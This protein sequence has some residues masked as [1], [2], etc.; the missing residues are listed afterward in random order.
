MYFYSF[1][2]YNCTEILYFFRGGFVILS[3][4]ACLS[5]AYHHYN[6]PNDFPVILISG[7][8]WR[9]PDTP[10]EKLFFHNC[11]EIGLCKS[12][13]GY[14]QFLQEQKTFQAGDIS[15]IGR[16]VAHHLYSANACSSNWSYLFVDL[17]LLLSSFYPLSL[18]ADEETIHMAL[19]NCSWLLSKKRH[20]RIYEIVLMMMESLANKKPNYQITVRSLM[21]V[22]VTYLLN[23]YKERK[24]LTQTEYS[25]PWDSP[26]ILPALKYIRVHYAE[27]FSTEILSGLCHMSSTNFRRTF[28]G[29]IGQS[30]HNY[31]IEVRIRIASSLLRATGESIS[32]ISE[33]IGFQSVSSFNRHFLAIMKTTPREWRQEADEQQLSPITTKLLS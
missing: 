1:L 4:K 18:L 23:L 26:S 29:T 19:S 14:I 5:I 15:I 17:Q 11:L 20:K 3:K 22:F 6:L 33:S 28:T 25:I 32:T 9:L 31:L 27:S 30:P 21:L 16:D 2:L 12:E 13:H 7:D 10:A 24:H 8:N